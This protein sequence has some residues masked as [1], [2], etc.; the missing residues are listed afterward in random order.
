[1]P[2]KSRIKDEKNL[3]QHGPV[4]AYRDR[5]A[6]EIVIETTKFNE[7]GAGIEICRLPM[8]RMREAQAIVALPDLIKAGGPFAALG[9]MVM[10]AEPEDDLLWHDDDVHISVAD[11]HRMTDAM[12]RACIA[13]ESRIAKPWH[14]DKGP[15]LR[16]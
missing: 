15:K 3:F 5:K 6:Q 11:A 13:P 10:A 7:E 12:E 16:P 9:I 4:R 1:M 8:D 14:K 2:M